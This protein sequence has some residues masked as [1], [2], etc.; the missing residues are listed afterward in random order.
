MTESG[1]EG[2]NQV[3]LPWRRM[4]ELGGEGKK[5]VLRLWRT[6]TNPWRGQG[7][8]VGWRTTSRVWVAVR[9]SGVEP[10]LRMTWVGGE[11]TMTRVVALEKPAMWMRLVV[12]KVPE[13]MVRG[14]STAGAPS[15]W[16]V[17][18]TSQPAS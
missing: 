12:V 1:G 6:M 8:V 3:I 10:S 5:Q 17:M 9:T 14:T 11:F 4:T 7:L 16:T 15:L 2:K 13:R 18:E